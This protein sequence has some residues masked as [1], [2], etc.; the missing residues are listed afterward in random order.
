MRRR[1]LA[2]LLVRQQ[3]RTQPQESDEGVVERYNAV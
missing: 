2:Q 1:V 3:G